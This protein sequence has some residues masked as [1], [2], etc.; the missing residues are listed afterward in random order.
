LT[1]VSVKRFTETGEAHHRR[2]AS[3]LIGIHQHLWPPAL[4][5]ALR[6][7]QSPPRLVGW[8]LELSGERAYDVRRADHDL[9]GRRV[10]AHQDGLDLVLL[11][12]SSPLGIE[13]LPPAQGLPLLTAWHDAVAELTTPFGGRG[14]RRRSPSR[15]RPPSRPSWTAG[16]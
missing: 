16:A 12:L 13:Q 10:L 15:T 6:L 14:P 3:V 7:R 11:S 4:V 2:G 9:E 5:E 8:R 1:I